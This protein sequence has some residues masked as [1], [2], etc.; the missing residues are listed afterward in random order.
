MQF[1]LDLEL[2]VTP[3]FNWSQRFEGKMMMA[4]VMMM[5]KYIFIHISL[6]SITWFPYGSYMFIK[7]N[8]KDHNATRNFRLFYWTDQTI[9][10]KWNDTTLVWQIKER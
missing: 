7:S 5:M 6:V 3:V 4:M 2:E 9:G 10:K 1:F 8:Q